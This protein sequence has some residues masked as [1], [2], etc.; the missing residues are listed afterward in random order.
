MLVRYC[1]IDYDREFAV[2]AEHSTEGRKRNIGVGRLVIE[3]DGDR[4]EFALLVA[5]DFQGKGLGTKL[6]D[7]LI[8]V[9]EEKGLRTIYGI[10]LSDNTRM[11]QLV[12]RLGFETRPH[13]E[14]MIAELRL[15]SS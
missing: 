10:I 15:K 8:G 7:V 12:T 9:G 4:G 2:I 14:G 5:D 3:P 1:N 6:L 11:I 13:P